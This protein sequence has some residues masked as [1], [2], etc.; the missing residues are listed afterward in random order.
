MDPEVIP[1]AERRD[2]V[3]R[4]LALCHI[5]NE[6]VDL[7]EAE[8]AAGSPVSTALHEQALLARTVLRETVVD[9]VAAGRAGHS[10]AA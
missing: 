8:S 3:R 6:L 9:L 10:D 4:L 7:A 5:V 1:P 2:T